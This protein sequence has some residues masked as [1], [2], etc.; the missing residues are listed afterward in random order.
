MVF[1]GGALFTVRVRDIVIGTHSSI[2]FW[3]SLVTPTVVLIIHVVP[4]NLYKYE[5]MP[6]NINITYPYRHGDWSVCK[7]F[8]KQISPPTTVEHHHPSGMVRYIYILWYP[9]I[10]KIYQRAH[11]TYVPLHR[12]LVQKAAFEGK[13]RKL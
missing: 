6:S 11:R 8:K 5:T 12:I 10:I 9:G 3:F 7:I 13:K 2:Y 4:T 1:A